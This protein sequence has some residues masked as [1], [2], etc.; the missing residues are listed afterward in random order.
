MLYHRDTLTVASRLV[1]KDDCRPALQGVHVKGGMVQVTDGHQLTRFHANGAPPVSEFPTTV[2]SVEPL[3]P[4]DSAVLTVES[5][6]LAVAAT[7]KRHMLPVLENVL[8]GNG[9]E[10]H[11]TLAAT[12][13]DSSH[14]GQHRVIDM[15]FPDC[16]KVFPVGNPVLTIGMDAAL[17]AKVFGQLATLSENKAAPALVTL[18]FYGPGK[19]MS[20]EFQGKHGKIDGL[21]MPC[22]LPDPTKV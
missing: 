21:I 4:E 1:S 5:I 12:N 3:G 6:K 18:R 2:P 15:Q 22:K 8:V 14:V 20:F 19:A 16:E 9:T 13:L 11:V 17:M 10:G 7:P